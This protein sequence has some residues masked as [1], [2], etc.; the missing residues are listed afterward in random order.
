M[1]ILQKQKL[2]A[3]FSPECELGMD[4]ALFYN[5]V[6]LFYKQIQATGGFAAINSSSQKCKKKQLAKSWYN[7]INITAQGMLLLGDKNTG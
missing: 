5:S 2:K 6:K 3:S 1:Y 4:I 7:I